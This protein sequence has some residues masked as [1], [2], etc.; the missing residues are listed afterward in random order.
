[1]AIRIFVSSTWEDLQPERKAIEN[2]VHRMQDAGF[3]GMEY[4][5]SRSGS[6]GVVS[7][8]EV[9][10][11]DIYIGIFAYRYGSGITEEEYRQARKLNIPC[12]IYFKDEEEPVK[13]KYVEDDPDRK[14]K[15]D[16]LKSEIQSG[17]ENLTTSSF[18]NPDNLTAKVVTDV[19]RLLN[20][21]GLYRRPRSLDTQ[22]QVT[23][24]YEKYMDL[25]KS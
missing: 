24:E 11:S 19:Y 9:S 20:S 5:G 18:T 23:S 8:E 12:L 3:V 16:S 15:L 25:I 7:L 4:F 1:M 14:A 6:P 22:C 10:H 21:E 2:C 13:R 17:N